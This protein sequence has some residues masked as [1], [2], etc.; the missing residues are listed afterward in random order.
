MSDVE[1]KEELVIDVRC[2]SEITNIDWRCTNGHGYCVFG[3]ESGKIYLSTLLDQ[4]A[5]T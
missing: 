3:T 1:V 5:S 2:D 4:S